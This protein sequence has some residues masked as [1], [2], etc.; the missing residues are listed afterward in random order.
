MLDLSLAILL[1][2]DW[3]NPCKCTCHALQEYLLTQM[4]VHSS[5]TKAL[6]NR[7]SESHCALKVAIVVPVALTCPRM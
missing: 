4:M 1:H 2:S 3:C 5:G 6:R 7:D